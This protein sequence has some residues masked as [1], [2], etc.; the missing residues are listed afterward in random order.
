MIAVVIL[1]ILGVTAI[2][3]GIGVGVFMFIGLTEE[4]GFLFWSFQLDRGPAITIAAVV[5]FYHV[6]VGALLLGV[7]RAIQ[8]GK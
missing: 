4:R 2:V 5:M 3:I 7:S 6:A 8:L 1:R